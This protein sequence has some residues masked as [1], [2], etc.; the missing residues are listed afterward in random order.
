MKNLRNF[1]LRWFL[2]IKSIFSARIHSYHTLCATPYT[3]H[4][5]APSRP[6]TSTYTTMKLALFL[7]LLT[8]GELIKTSVMAQE[9]V[10][11]MHDMLIK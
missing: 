4:I 10:L 9:I 1:L 5:A 11:R 8:L 3:T 2:I 7:P 6:A